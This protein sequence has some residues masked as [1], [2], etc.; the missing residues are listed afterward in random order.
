V[1]LAKLEQA[2]LPGA[3]VLL[4]TTSLAA[5]FGVE[6]TSKVAAALIDGFIRSGRN[7]A[8]VSAVTAAELLVRP[9]RSGRSDAGASVID[10]VRWFPNVDIASVDLTVASIAAQIRAH[11]GMKMVDAL[12]AAC[13]LDRSAGV[14]VSDDA[15]WPDRLTHRDATMRVLALSSFLPFA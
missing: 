10:F 6:P 2:I 11:E 1:T 15:G 13:G 8:V 5:Y 12:I 3:A 14:A 9:V 7:S 4:D